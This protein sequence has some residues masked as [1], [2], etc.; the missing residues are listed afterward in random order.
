MSLADAIRRLATTLPSLADP[1]DAD[2]YLALL[3]RL[4]AVGRQDLPLG[5]LFEGHI[6]AGQIV[7]RYGAPDQSP[8]AGAV[9][10][11]WNAD[12]PGEPPRLTRDGADWRLTGA[13]AYAS[14][15][16]VLTHALVGVDAD[17]GRQ[18]VLLDLALV[19]PT[20]DRG[21][22]QVIGMQRSETHVVRW[23][24]ERVPASALIGQVGDY[25][26]EP[27]FGGGALRF[28]AVQAGG[29]AALFDRVR[30]HLIATGRAADPHQAARLAE[31]FVVADGI[32]GVVR[33]AARRWFDEADDVRLPR[34][35]AAR[36]AVLAAG[37]RALMLA[38]AA[39]GLPGMFVAHP[40]SATIADL[41]VYLRQPAPDAQ[42]MRVAA[43]AAAGL[44]TPEL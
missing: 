16:G 44:L 35:A 41:S 20:I 5:R 7:R 32:A 42:R 40:L 9:L 4:H 18:L 38:E 27:W 31:L 23:S 1:V 39:V 43:A 24:N 29:V 13:K 33:T 11:V 6:D 28:V 19:P 30:D 22:W 26:R 15:A 14:G 34:V 17:G 10:G 25:A 12:L 8:P 37:E 21:W 3:R 2:G 36:A